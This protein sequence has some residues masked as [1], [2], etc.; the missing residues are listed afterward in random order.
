MQQFH[1]GEKGVF[2]G[3]L[4]SRARQQ[5][6][7]APLRDGLEATRFRYALAAAGMCDLKLRY[8]QRAFTRMPNSSTQPLGL[9]TIQTNF[10][11]SIFVAA[12][13]PRG[14]NGDPMLCG[15]LQLSVETLSSEP[16]CRARL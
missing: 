14:N 10:A 1:P 15:P 12:V 2:A 6:R 8:R 7:T 13:D 5:P 3:V 16:S 11:G 9:M 4:Q